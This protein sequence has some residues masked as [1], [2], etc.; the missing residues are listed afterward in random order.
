LKTPDIH[1]YYNKDDQHHRT[2][3]PAVIWADGSKEWWINN[4]WY[5]NGDRPPL[6]WLDTGGHY[7]D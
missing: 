3:G 6:K 4:R 1:K 5:G 2:D 7:E